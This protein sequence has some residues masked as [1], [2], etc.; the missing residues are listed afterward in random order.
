MNESNSL[1]TNFQYQ[2]E[3]CSQPN[4]LNIAS[5][6]QSYDAFENDIQSD[7]NP[8]NPHHIDCIGCRN[9][10]NFQLDHMDFGG[11]LY[12]TGNYR[13]YP[14]STSTYTRE[15]LMN[16]FNTEKYMLLFN[17]YK[18]TYEEGEKINDFELLDDF[19]TLIRF[20]D[21]AE[22]PSIILN[23]KKKYLFRG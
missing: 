6:N 3:I 1:S 17:F 5:I 15:E 12:V 10:S 8:I 9:I 4:S 19:N 13:D 11:C 14:N 18:V 20:I 23:L 7:I 22:V 16:I 21:N 2:T